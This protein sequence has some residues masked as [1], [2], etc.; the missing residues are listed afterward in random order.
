[1]SKLFSGFFSLFGTEDMKKRKIP[2]LQYF[3]LRIPSPIQILLL[4][5]ENPKKIQK[6]TPLTLPTVMI[7]HLYEDFDSK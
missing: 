3:C 4:E 6:S 1:M 7:N 5:I 2:F